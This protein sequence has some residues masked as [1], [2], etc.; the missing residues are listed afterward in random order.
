MKYISSR[1]AESGLT[2]QQVLFSG[3]AKDGGLYFP[4]SIP[5][6]SAE[7]LASWQHLS[8]PD[9][10]ANVMTMFIEETEIPGAD[11]KILI[12]KAFTKFKDAQNPITIA[13]LNNNLNIAELFHGPTL[14]FK[15]SI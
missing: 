7:T 13:K 1:G 6:I 11:L 8:Y 12:E 15:A 10:V 3:Y 5:V 2:F 14:A 9:I 4:E